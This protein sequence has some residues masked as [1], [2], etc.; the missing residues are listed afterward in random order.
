MKRTTITI[1]TAALFLLTGFG[2]PTKRPDGT[3]LTPSKVAD[4]LDRA[5]AAGRIDELPV[6]VTV[7]P[8]T[9]EPVDRASEEKPVT[10]IYR[11]E[12]EVA[13]HQLERAQQ[14]PISPDLRI[15][16]SLPKSEYRIGEPVIV[17][18]TLMNISD[19]AVEIAPLLDPQFQ[20]A[21]YF[22][23]TPEGRTHGLSPVA[24]A[25]SR[26]NLQVE[27]LFP[28]E[29]RIEDVPVFFHKQ[30]WVFTEPGDYAIHV[31]YLGQTPDSA[32]IES[33]TLHFTVIEGTPEDRAAAELA[34]GHEQGLF[35]LWNQGD[36]LTRGIA[37]M[38]EIIERFPETTLALYARYALG[39]NMAQE[40]W[41]G[42]KGGEIRP[43]LPDRA[44]AYLA[45]L[46][47]RL[48][49]RDAPILPPH[50]IA[51]TYA[52]LADA[53]RKLGDDARARDVLHRFMARYGNDTRF[54]EK[55]L[56]QIRSLA[57]SF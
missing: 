54:S 8:V 56:T 11:P 33:N 19:R 25:C 47:D 30:G 55:D 6:T 18:A 22:V 1:T 5:R 4:S 49:R 45:P 3:D 10:G 57:T 13:E 14:L 31:T 16:L 52:M 50:M 32:R 40:F 53:Y 43:A 34:M 9:V 23:T 12:E 7:T 48:D 42:A 35:L 17:R 28:H 38:E 24:I 29:N 39:S 15:D 37:A 20:F 36:H 44:A 26:G 46:A 41:N 27:T 51:G 2:A 21:H